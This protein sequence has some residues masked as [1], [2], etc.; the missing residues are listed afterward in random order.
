MRECDKCVPLI[1]CK[2]IGI[3]IL[4][5]RL[6][7]VGKS[8]TATVDITDDYA[9]TDLKRSLPW[10]VVASCRSSRTSTPSTSST[11]SSA[12]THPNARWD[13]S[14]L[15]TAAESNRAHEAIGASDMGTYEAEILGP[16]I[17]AE[18]SLD[19]EHHSV[20]P[21]LSYL[22]IE[23]SGADVSLPLPKDEPTENDIRA[24]Y[25]YSASSDSSD[26]ESHD[27]DSDPDQ[28]DL[29]VS[30]Y[31]TQPSSE[32]LAECLLHG[33]IEIVDDYL[34]Q[35]VP[36]RDAHRWSAAVGPLAGST[37]SHALRDKNDHHTNDPASIRRHTTT[38][39]LPIGK[40]ARVIKPPESHNARSTAR[41]LSDNSDAHG[42]FTISVPK[43]S[44]AKGRR[45]LV[46]SNKTALVTAV[47]MRGDLQFIDQTKRCSDMAQS[48]YLQNSCY[49][50]V[51]SESHVSLCPFTRKIGLVFVMSLMR[52]T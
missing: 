52:Y 13:G 12:L 15:D 5:I 34:A 4:G 42:K 33:P 24:Y 3:R 19:M 37:A 14:P 48:M 46:P 1:N 44:Y 40:T 7:S 32:D 8:T 6:R 43:T 22:T 16:E 20:S 27:D 25:P 49:A 35:E 41:E 28:Q 2:L 36:L 26:S 31:P 10:D 47:Y 51:A 30:H 39:N 50:A 18:E 9:P 29:P 23:G 21:A 17:P 45:L 38:H 11:S